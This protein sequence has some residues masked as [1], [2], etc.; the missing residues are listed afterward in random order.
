M[1]I[2]FGGF[3]QED[4]VVPAAVGSE[5][6]KSR[7]K[8][9]GFIINEGIKQNKLKCLSRVQHCNFLH[10]LLCKYIIFAVVVFL[11]AYSL[12]IRKVKCK[13]A[14]LQNYKRPKRHET[15]LISST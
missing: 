10:H 7:M 2:T 4:L 14:P 8:N 13:C 11:F 6:L 5:N 1:R 15:F 3:I 9:S 12:P